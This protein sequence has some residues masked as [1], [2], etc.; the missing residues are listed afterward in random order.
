MT[1]LG[2]VGM[3]GLLGLVVGWRFKVSLAAVLSA[4]ALALTWR[5]TPQLL[6]HTSPLWGGDAEGYRFAD[7]NFDWGQGLFLAFAAADRVGLKPVAFLH[8]GDPH[9]GV[10]SHRTMITGADPRSIAE[11]MRGKFLVVSVHELYHSEAEAPTRARPNL[12]PLYRSLQEIGFDGRLT[13]TA[14]YFDLRSPDR[15]SQLMKALERA[16]GP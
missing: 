9:Y 1:S 3:A 8:S 10:P 14:F 12:F 13:D 4:T 15:F 11:T 7:A 2:G 5:S 6:T 16:L